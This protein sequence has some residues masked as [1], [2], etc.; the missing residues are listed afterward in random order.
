MIN[1]TGDSVVARVVTEW[2][3]NDGQNTLEKDSTEMVK[4]Y[5]GYS[6]KTMETVDF[7]TLG[8][9]GVEHRSLP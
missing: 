6:T 2:T 1:V 5:T 9:D 3:K 8:V 4:N 7:D